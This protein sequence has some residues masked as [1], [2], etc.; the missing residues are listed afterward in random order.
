MGFSSCTVAS[1]ATWLAVTNAPCV[2]DDL[3]IR[4][5]MGDVIRAYPSTTLLRST[6]AWA[7]TTSACDCGGVLVVLL[8]HRIDLYQLRTAAGIE[9][10][11]HQCSL[12]THE[13]CLGAGQVRAIR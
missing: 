12:R 2:T 3:P 9:L 4:P 11:C 7:A 13:A 5:L 10:V 6:A 8:A 1:G